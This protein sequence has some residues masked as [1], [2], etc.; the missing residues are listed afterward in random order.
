MDPTGV[1]VVMRSGEEEVEV[2]VPHLTPEIVVKRRGQQW[3][4][5]WSDQRMAGKMVYVVYAK[6]GRET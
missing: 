6:V 4:A 2:R 5:T 3:F 1:E